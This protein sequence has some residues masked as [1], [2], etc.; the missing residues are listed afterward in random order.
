[1]TLQWQLKHR[2]FLIA[3]QWHE[4][5]PSGVS[6]INHKNNPGVIHMKGDI[7]HRRY[8]NVYKN[9]LI[10]Y[11]CN[12]NINFIHQNENPVI[13]LNHLTTQGPTHDVW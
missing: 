10:S 7:R 4:S 1:M 12:Q 2:Y 8:T 6:I 5:L 9:V 13:P 3:S 11:S